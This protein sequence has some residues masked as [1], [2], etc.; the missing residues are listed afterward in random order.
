M[1]RWDQDKRPDVELLADFRN[2]QLQLLHTRDR[3]KNALGKYEIEKADSKI[4]ESYQELRELYERSNNRI[5]ELIYQDKA[6]GFET[7]AWFLMLSEETQ[8]RLR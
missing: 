5:L 1:G 2:L 8:K 4:K 3:R 7:F 6:E